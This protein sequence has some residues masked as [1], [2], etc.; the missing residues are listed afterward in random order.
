[1][2]LRGTGRS[3]T[4]IKAHSSFGT[5]KPLVTLGTT[6]GSNVSGVRVERLT[7]DCNNVATSTGVICDKGQEMCG[8]DYVVVQNFKSVGIQMNTGAADWEL[9]NLEVYPSAT[10]ATKGIYANTSPGSNV[11]RKATVGV[12]GVL[13][14]GIHISLGTCV[15]LDV[16]LDNC[17]D[18]ILFA[19][20]DGAAIGVAGP[21]AANVTSLV[22]MDN[23][24]HN[25][26]V[27]SVT[28]GSATNSVKDDFFTKTITDAF[29][30]SAVMGDLY[31]GR[32]DHYGDRIGFFNT[33]AVVKGAALTASPAAAP[34]GGT[35][36]AAG[37]WDTAAN[38]DAAIA[39]INGLRTRLNDLVS[40]LQA[41]GLIP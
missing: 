1:V 11:I 23:T 14:I 39:T 18:G 35:G 15:V 28:K 5:G 34:A 17:T 4:T 21:S 9:S 10:G 38:R 7:I 27:A 32:L 31:I 33:T 26:Y 25:V 37:G 41:Y 24:Q 20:S 2:V 6:G 40:R 22:R 36:T 16:R 3:A 8:L 29:V 13:T 12:A 30:Q 19:G